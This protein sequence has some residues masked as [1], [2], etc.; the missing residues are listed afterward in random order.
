MMNRIAL[1]LVCSAMLVLS[2]C[3]SMSSDE[4][5]ASDWHAIGY[6]DGSRGYASD[7]MGHYRKMCGKHGV[8][9]D[10]SEYQAGRRDGLKEF[11]QP[12]RGYNL[13]S[14]GG[15]YNGVCPAHLE[16]DFLDAY[17]VGA[18]LHTLRSN[19]NSANYQI[20]ARERELEDLE[21][22]V[23]SKQATLIAA[24][25]TVQ[26]RVLILA[27]LENYSERKG[28]LEAEILDL[29]EDRAHHE[30]ELASYEAVLADSGY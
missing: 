8:T 20:S 4:C 7:R 22:L 5:M 10:F 12:Q 14:S 15:R 24:E 11:C 30:A 25:T 18:R 3:A 2:G 21:D 9:P 13:G 23:R 17:R 28:Q 29:I 27:D 6:E 26:D 1:V 16:P 19:V